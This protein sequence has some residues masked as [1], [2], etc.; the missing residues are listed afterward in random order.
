MAKKFSGFSTSIVPDK[1]STSQFIV[2]YSGQDNAQWTMKALADEIGGGDNIYTADGTLGG[3][4][5]VSMDGN[6]LTFSSASGYPIIDA[7]KFS[8]YPNGNTTSTSTRAAFLSGNIDFN[9]FGHNANAIGLNFTSYGTA[10]RGY[11]FGLYGGGAW[12]TN[13]G[14]SVIGP[15]FTYTSGNALN[16]RLGVIG[17]G[18]TNATYSLRVQNSDNNDIVK[19]FD[20]QTI[21]LGYNAN[22]ITT[23]SSSGGTVKLNNV[24]GDPLFSAGVVSGS[25]GK[26]NVYGGYYRT[27]EYGASAGLVFTN[28]AGFHVA[29][30][31]SSMLTCVSSTKGFLPPRMTTT[32]RDAIN[33]GTFATGLTLYNTTDNKLQFYNGTAWTD[34]G[35]GGGDNIY[36]ADG[37]ITSPTHRK[38]TLAGTST[39]PNKA[40]LEVSGAVR[41]GDFKVGNGYVNN[42]WAWSWSMA[43]NG[44]VADRHFYQA[45]FYAGSNHE[46]GAAAVAGTNYLSISSQGLEHHKVSVGVGINGTVNDRLVVKGQGQTTSKYTARFLDG[47]DN[48][49][50][51]LR[52]DRLVTLTSP[53][54]LKLT[55]GSAGYGNTTLTPYSPTNTDGFKI[56]NNVVQFTVGSYGCAVNANSAANAKLRVA[57]SGVPGVNAPHLHVITNTNDTTEAVVIENSDGT[58]L[59]NMKENGRTS[60]SSQVSVG[61]KSS[62]AID[63]ID[64]DDGNIQEVTLASGANDFDPTNE[65]PGSTYILKI[66]Q[67]SSADGT[68]DWEST[69]ATVNWPGGTAPT[70]T[71]ANAAIDVVTLVC[72]AANTYYGTS[73]LNFS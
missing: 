71:A 35:G 58:D 36:T 47:A 26:I 73:A 57:P 55:S 7:G 60:F 61:L 38:I 49:I 4:R 33:S 2:G 18:N 48:D 62:A 34:A 44:F 1:T 51:T 70:L 68:I 65:I 64:W 28:Q 53:S 52:D 25:T 46:T 16:A 54:G 10:I 8:I 30:D 42:K 22:Q 24:S 5:T 21:R 9:Y 66:T 15:D 67:P 63:G 37:T 41:Q 14:Y 17:K 3:A 6:N 20:D 72:T 31:A 29:Q 40:S 27:F 59:L 69:T 11:G 13:G 43:A 50:L 39:Q 45:N 56:S 12:S 32:Q 23:E 19:I